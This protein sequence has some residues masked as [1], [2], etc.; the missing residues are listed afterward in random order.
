MIMKKTI[1][2]VFFCI[3]GIVI[4]ST[5]SLLESN[6]T[7]PVKVSPANWSIK[8]NNNLIGESSE[9]EITD[10]VWSGN[11]NVKPGKA[12]PGTNGY[13]S[14]EIDPSDVDVAFIY[15]FTIDRTELL[16]E[17]FRIDSIETEGINLIRTGIDTYSGIFSLEDISSNTKKNIKFNLYWENN[18]ENNEVDS[19]YVGVNKTINIP[20]T[21]K[22]SQYLGETLVEYN[23]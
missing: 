19:E 15:S 1:F 10:I 6:I 23:D 5:F 7:S 22:F 4:I 3:F 14:I 11:E 13:F 17:Y 16:N 9:F 18:E 2:L 20:I 8:V 12:A 21:M